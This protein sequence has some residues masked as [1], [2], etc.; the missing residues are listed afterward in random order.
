MLRWSFFSVWVAAEL[1]KE[2]KSWAGGRPGE[3]HRICFDLTNR[4]QRVLLTRNNRQHGSS[5][6]RLVSWEREH[7][8]T[9][10]KMEL[11]VGNKY[12]LGRKIG[13]GSFGDIYLGE[14]L[15]IYL[16]FVLTNS[17]SLFAARL[18]RYNDLDWRGSSYQT[19]MH[20]HETSPA[21]H[22]K[23]ILQNDARR[24]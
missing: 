18:S 5:R 7:T 15:L 12:R 8:Q 24:R 10:C 11:R 14:E 2:E 9:G 17:V 23:Q 20:S 16:Q 22:R 6:C 19:R 21:T 13:S 1:R 3:G 4:V